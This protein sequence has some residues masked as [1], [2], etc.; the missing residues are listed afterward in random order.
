[1]L[2]D[3]LHAAFEDRVIALNGVDIDLRASFS[4]GVA[5]LAT[6]VINGVVF[7]KLV[8]KLGVARGFIG[9]HMRLLRK[10]L[11]NDWQDF[12]LC[13]FVHMERTSRSATLHKRQNRVLVFHALLNLD[14]LLATN[15]GL[16]NLDNRAAP[17]HRR[18]LA[19]AQRFANAMAHEPRAFQRDPQGAVKLVGA[20]ALFARANH[21]DGV[22]PITHLDMAFL[23]NGPDLDGEGLAAG[24]ALVQADPIALGFERAALI[25]N[26]AMRTHAAIGPKPRLNIGIGGSLIVE[27]WSREN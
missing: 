3:A 9:H 1:M 10:V 7:G 15:E 18:K 4:V 20:H 11:A 2:V 16:I 12:R 26:P 5:V 13:H 22:Q 24:I 17:A 8:A 21:V 25:D 19:R 6:R 27:V 23:E 14:A